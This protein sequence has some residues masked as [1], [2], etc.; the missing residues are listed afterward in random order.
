[1]PDSPFW[2]K[3]NS[4]CVMCTNS[5]AYI[6]EPDEKYSLEKHL[7]KIREL[8]AN[9]DDR[10]V[11]YRNGEHGGYFLFTGGEPTLH[12]KFF[13][14]LG[15]YRENFPSFAMTLLT[16]GRTFCDEGFARDTLRVGGVP[17]DLCIPIHGPDAKTHDSVTRSP[18]SFAETVAGLKHLL[19]HRRPGQGVEVRVILHRHPVR[20]LPDTLR[21]LLSE[22]PDTSLYRLTLV[23]FESEGQAAKNLESI[24]VPLSAAAARIAGAQDLLARFAEARLYHFPLCVLPDTLWTKAWRTLPSYEIRHVEACRRCAMSDLCAGPHDWYAPVFGEAEFQAFPERRRVVQTGNPFNPIEAVTQETT[25]WRPAPPVDAVRD[26][27]ARW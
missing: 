27:S 10:T 16:N 23:Y 5:D 14:L 17:F 2:Q 26:P 4:H 3:C 19:K 11:F 21:F 13:R 22:F 12:P 9:P 8:K 7:E 15:A 6:M 20:W 25:P 18:G 24:K 1:M